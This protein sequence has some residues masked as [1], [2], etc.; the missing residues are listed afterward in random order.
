M[1]EAIIGLAG[2]GKTTRVVKKLEEEYFSDL[3]SFVFTSL[4]NATL[5]AFFRKFGK[6]KKKEQS[7]RTIYGLAYLELWRNNLLCDKKKELLGKAFKQKIK[8]LKQEDITPY[9]IRY[10]DQ[11]YTKYILYMLEGTSPEKVYTEIELTFKPRTASKLSDVIRRLVALYNTNKYYDYIHLLKEAIEHNLDFFNVYRTSRKSVDVFNDNPLIVFDEFQDVP[12][13][14][15]KHLFKVKPNANVLFAGDPFQAIFDW[16]I[17][18]PF[19]ALKVVKDKEFLTQTRRF[20]ANITNIANRVLRKINKGLVLL[21]PSENVKDAVVRKYIEQDMLMPFL[22]KK[23]LALSKHTNEFAVLVRT[24]DQ[25]KKIHD[26]LKQRLEKYNIVVVNLEEYDFERIVSIYTEKKEIEEMKRRERE[27]TLVD[28]F[29]KKEEKDIE[30][31]IYKELLER[32]GHHYSQ[33]I[34]AIVKELPLVF[35]STVHSAKGLDFDV[36]FFYDKI[37]K[38]VFRLLDEGI[39]TKRNEL[40]VVYVAVTRAKKLLYILQDSEGR[41]YFEQFAI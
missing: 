7:V 16:L 41:G 12:R 6:L 21:K 2:T 23:I 31:E 17:V 35:V 3:R 37:P 38:L 29:Q 4:T 8:L 20:G 40:E 27:I 32:Y 19:L 1:K 22:A 26:Y 11:Y 34:D 9:Y 24:R 33:I 18:D 25:A 10:L 5:K 39:I 13:I 36:V 14:L 28:Y 15:Y 30:S